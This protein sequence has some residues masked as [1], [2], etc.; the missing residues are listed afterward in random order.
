MKGQ[1]SRYFKRAEFACKCGCGFDAVDAE[2]LDVLHHARWTFMSP[3]IITSGCRCRVHNAAV[4]GAD[5]SQHILAKAAD[6]QVVRV[7]PREVGEH[8]DEKYPG[9]YG[10]KI[11]PTWVH[12]DVR[13]ERW[14]G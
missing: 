10:V 8:L 14:R 11:Y 3:L 5:D 2:L 4:G 7:T 1:I 12:I 13:A 9:K 6:I